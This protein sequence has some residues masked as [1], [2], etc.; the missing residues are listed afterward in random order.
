MLWAMV[1]RTP[2]PAGSKMPVASCDEGDMLGSAAPIRQ[3]GQSPRG[4]SA[5]SVAPQSGHVR[6]GFMAKSSP[7]SR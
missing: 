1:S 3:L 2:G 5:G 6:S 7:D 4:A